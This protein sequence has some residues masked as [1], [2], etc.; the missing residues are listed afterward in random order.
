[1]QIVYNIATYMFVSSALMVGYVWLK[2][3]QSSKNG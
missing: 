3:K 2:N 1:M